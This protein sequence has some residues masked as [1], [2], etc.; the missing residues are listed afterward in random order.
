MENQVTNCVKGRRDE[1]QTTDIEVFADEQSPEELLYPK[2][3]LSNPDILWH[4]SIG[5]ISGS[6]FPEVD[7]VFVI[8]CKAN[9]NQS[10]LASCSAIPRLYVRLQCPPALICKQRIRIRNDF[11][12]A[13]AVVQLKSPGIVVEG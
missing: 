9:K 8:E 13:A 2:S 7:V 1:K 6:F 5:R 10:G 4:F 3:W 12:D 11:L